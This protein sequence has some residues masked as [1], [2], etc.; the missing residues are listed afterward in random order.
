MRNPLDTKKYF[1]SFL[2]TLVVFVSV[3][4]LNNFL[5]A[6][7]YNEIRS[8]QDDIELDFISSETQFDLLKEVSC[9]NAPADSL[10]SRE[11]GA[12]A[13]KLSYI[14]ASDSGKESDELVYLKKKYSLL[15]IKDHLLMT[16]LAEKCPDTPTTIMYF[17]GNSEDCPDCGT[18][19]GVLTYLRQTYPEE[20][21]IY[22]FDYNL[23]LSALD[24]LKS[25]YRIEKELPAL[26]IKDNVYYGSTTIDQIKEIL[27][28]LKKIDKAREL[29]EEKKAAANLK[30]QNKEKAS[31]TSTTTGSIKR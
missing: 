5:D 19:G 15:Q 25:V 20:L 3:V 14:E 24:T 16:R 6:R 9:K 7:R 2:I 18:V 28:E 26:V 21:R 12:L 23:E 29:E 31:T 1:L 4:S 22:S 11:L 8:V 27:P 13:S 30:A 17:Y 10:L